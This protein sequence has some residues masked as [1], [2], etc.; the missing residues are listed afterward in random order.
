MALSVSSYRRLLSPLQK[1]SCYFMAEGMSRPPDA[2]DFKIAKRIV[3]Q[4]GS[5]VWF[6]LYPLIVEQTL[7]VTFEKS[8]TQLLII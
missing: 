7:E 5:D 3:D 8:P 4:T 1:L 6:F 2:R